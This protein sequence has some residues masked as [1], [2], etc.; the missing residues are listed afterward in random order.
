VK[1]FAPLR[2]TLLRLCVKLFAPSRELFAPLREI[3]PVFAPCQTQTFGRRALELIRVFQ[4]T[5]NLGFPDGGLKN[6]VLRLNSF[7]RIW[8]KGTG[9]VDLLKFLRI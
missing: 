4:D 1:L 9:L 3:E 5:D 6:G 7:S 8:I 2:E